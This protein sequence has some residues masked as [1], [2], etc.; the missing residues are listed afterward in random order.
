MNLLLKRILILFSVALNIGFVIMTL[1]TVHQH[2][3]SFR[4]RS[5]QELVDIVKTLKLPP[6]EEDA[7]METIT[8]FRGTPRMRTI[9][10]PNRP[11]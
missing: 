7:V 11:T 5:W 3:T 10:T 1:S 8:Q 4:E 9:G 6:A 2:Q